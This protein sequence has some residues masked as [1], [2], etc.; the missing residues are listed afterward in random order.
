MPI[1]ISIVTPTRNMAHFLEACIL[2]VMQQGYPNLEHIVVD[3]ASTDNSREIL[4]RYPLLRWISEP[5]RGLSDG[6]NKSLRMATG[7]IIGWCNA[8][9]LYLPGAALVAGE[10]FEKHPDVDV[11][12][13]DYRETDGEGRSIRV[14]RE[15]HFSRFVFRWLH[16]NHIATPATFWRRRLHEDGLWFDEKFRYAMDYDFLHRALA[17][18]YKFRHV[19]VL[20]TDFRRHGGSLT[21]TGGQLIEHEMLVRR[22]AGAP[23][24]KLGPA[25]P[26]ARK[27]L[28]VAARAVRSA[29]RCCRGYYFEQR[30]Q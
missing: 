9:D 23:W 5:D 24:N 16:F 2:S 12:Y 10:Y 14:F 27:F 7:D 17:K 25:Y 11:L 6:L 28:L 22:E 8:D 3:G 20:F 1:K 26:L 29:E 4:S 15:T 21:A 30:H 18:G 19:S 13:G